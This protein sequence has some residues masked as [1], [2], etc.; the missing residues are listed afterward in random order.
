MPCASNSCGCKTNDLKRQITLGINRAGFEKLT[1]IRAMLEA[2]LATP[3][4]VASAARLTPMQ[5]GET[6]HAVI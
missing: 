5:D 1:A 4:P 3:S 2:E 6:I